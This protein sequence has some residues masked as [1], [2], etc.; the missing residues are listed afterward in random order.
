[1]RILICVVLGILRIRVCRILISLGM[2]R[3]RLGMVLVLRLA[4]IVRIVAG[5]P[6][7]IVCHVG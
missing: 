2:G 4:L 5:V 3:W 6:I 7:T 1:M